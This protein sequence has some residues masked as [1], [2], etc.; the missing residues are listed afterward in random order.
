MSN[1]ACSCSCLVV[2]R[3]HTNCFV[4]PF[5][6]DGITVLH[7]QLHQLFCFPFFSRWDYSFA[8]MASEHCEH[9]FYSGQHHDGYFGEDDVASCNNLHR[10]MHLVIHLHLQSAIHACGQL[11]CWLWVLQEHNGWPEDLLSGWRISGE[12][13]H[14]PGYTRMHLSKW[15]GNSF[16]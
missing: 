11:P 8:C 14:L 4:S 16:R 6:R 10:A 1:S 3:S 12:G 5:S 15:G 13:V 7:W 2:A 9:T